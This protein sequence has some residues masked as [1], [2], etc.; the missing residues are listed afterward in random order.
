MKTFLK[1]GWKILILGFIVIFIAR[2]FYE[3]F[4]PHS[5]NGHSQA[6]MMSSNMGFSKRNFA[7]NIQL[8]KAKSAKIQKTV[9]VEQKYEKIADINTIT[10][11]FNADKK[12][13]YI[14]IKEIKGIVQTQRESDKGKKRFLFLS[15]G[16]KP[17]EFDTFVEKIKKIGVIK[18][19]EISKK[20]MTNEFHQLMSQRKSLEKKLIEISKL[21][22]AKGKISEKINLQEKIYQIENQL[23]SFGLKLGD[24]DFEHEFCTVKF[25][26][27][28][29]G[30][31]TSFLLLFISSIF[32]AFKWA[33]S[34]TII[35]LGI[36]LLG[37]LVILLIVT[38]L[39]K[40]GLFKL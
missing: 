8:Y 9:R 3:F 15:V 30:R 14:L 10:K 22:T 28:E 13:I 31:N 37:S 32:L 18:S 25:T 6:I 17:I 27:Q 39:N 35:S 23:R 16:I 19:F 26:L 24:Y 38:I 34:V 33:L 40:S 5:D 36:I 1:K 21:K 2:L 12:K 29:D 20:D 7:S 4:N 11:Y